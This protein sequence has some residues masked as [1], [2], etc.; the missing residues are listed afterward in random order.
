[1]SLGSMLFM[2]LYY[3]GYSLRVLLNYQD[4]F[5]ISF[6]DVDQGDSIV[7]HTKEGKTVVVDGGG[8]Y[9]A[10]SKLASKF[11][12]N[13]CTID[14]IFITHEHFDHLGGIPRILQYC[15]V[16]SITFNDV[17][18]FSRTCNS[19]RTY[20]KPKKIFKGDTFLFNELYIETLWPTE[21]YTNVGS[22]NPNG[23]SLVLF[24]D[25]GDFEALLTGDA[26]SHILDNI[27]ISSILPRVQGRFDV[28]KAPHHGA[29]N[30][31]STV[32][33]DQLRPE[34]CVIPVGDDNSYGHPH[35]E[36]LEYFEKI[37]C[38]IHRTDLDGDIEFR[39]R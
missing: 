26:E 20:T 23:A 34:H 6:L 12:M 10:S 3:L 19:I 11:L 13:K 28:Y 7:L 15:E 17:N 22:D 32:L 21:R 31:L 36:T 14:H 35:K 38:S 1:M 16:S 30:G 2:L 24:V 8:N 33:L 18:C 25:Y 37:G 9:I 5:S 29:R 39:V 27:D 4:F